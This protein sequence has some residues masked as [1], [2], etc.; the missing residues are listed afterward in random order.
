MK[1]L[2][3]GGYIDGVALILEVTDEQL[4]RIRYDNKFFFDAAFLAECVKAKGQHAHVYHLY[5][6]HDGDER[7]LAGIKRLEQEYKSVSWWDKSTSKFH[8]R[9][10][11]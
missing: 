10:G 6:D 7:L 1:A 8:I 5:L 9:R 4:D 11:E 2:G 3:S